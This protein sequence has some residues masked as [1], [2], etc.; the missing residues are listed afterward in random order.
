MG[1]VSSVASTAAGSGLSAGVGT[2]V[3]TGVTKPWVPEKFRPSTRDPVAGPTTISPRKTPAATNTG[4]GVRGTAEG[5]QLR[6]LLVR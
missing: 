2:D 5:Y 4:D 1:K 3:A 6:G